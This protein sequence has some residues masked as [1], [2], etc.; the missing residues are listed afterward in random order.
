MSKK[1][2][3][4]HF[5]VWQKDFCKMCFFI[6]VRKLTSD[7]KISGKTLASLVLAFIHRRHLWSLKVVAA[8]VPDYA[9]HWQSTY[10]FRLLDLAG[11]KMGVGY[12]L[13]HVRGTFVRHDQFLRYPQFVK[14]EDSLTQASSLSIQSSFISRLTGW[15]YNAFTLSF[16]AAS[17]F[18]TH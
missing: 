2:I 7:R 16:H 11:S 9:K 15:H 3:I 5:L 12:I 4:I 8:F 14:I 13:R 18:L 1:P 10:T 6:F 17:V